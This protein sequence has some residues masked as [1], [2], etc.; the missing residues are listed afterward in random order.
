MESLQIQN[1]KKTQIEKCIP[2]HTIFNH[3]INEL[4]KLKKNQFYTNN[5][6][7][8]KYLQI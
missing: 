8:N 7:N 1:I 5:N 4:T 2:D 6:N 3:T